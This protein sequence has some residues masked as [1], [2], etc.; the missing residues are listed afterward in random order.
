M[1]TASPNTSEFRNLAGHNSG[2]SPPHIGAINKAIIRIIK[3]IYS[4]GTVKTLATWL[5]LTVKTAKNRL[6]GA[7][8]FSLDEVG[9]LLGSEHGFKVLTAIMDAA[10]QRPGYR[11][12]DWWAVCEP[13]MDLADAERLCVAVRKRTDKAIRKREDVADALEIEI[14]R[15]QTVAIHGEGPARQHVRAHRS[16]AGKERGLVAAK[17]ARR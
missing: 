12:P 11:V 6:D 9:D 10:A 5:R 14:R 1:A 13:L 15:A 2:L 8:E 4:A 17:G 16:Y 7:R 3:D